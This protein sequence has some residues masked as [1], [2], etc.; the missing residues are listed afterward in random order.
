MKSVLY[1]PRF[2]SARHEAIQLLSRPISHAALFGTSDLSTYHFPILFER[3]RG[4]I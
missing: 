4:N 3:P 2:G 1:Y